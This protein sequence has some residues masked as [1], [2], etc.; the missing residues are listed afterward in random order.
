MGC[1]YYI[2]KK[3]YIY[4]KNDR[5]TTL[6]LLEHDRGYFYEINIDEDEEDYEEKIEKSIQEQL[7]P[8]MKPISIYLNDVFCKPSFE[9]KY[10]SLILQHLPRDKVWE[11][12]VKIVKKESRYII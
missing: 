6:I 11:D 4:Y 8:K 12:I 1:D 5:N 10:K 3:L 7:E 2:Y 9:E